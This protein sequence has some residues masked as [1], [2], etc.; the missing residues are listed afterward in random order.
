MTSRRTALVVSLSVILLAALFWLVTRSPFVPYNIRELIAQ[1]NPILSVLSLSCFLHWSFGLP[2]LL[3]GWLARGGWRAWMFPALTLLHG[4]IAWVLLRVSVP[5][6]S[7]HDVV[8]SAVLGWPWEWELIARF[9]AL[10]GVLSLAAS[11][12][13]I[14][15]MLSCTA[16]P[17]SMYL[18]GLGCALVLA[19]LLHWVVVVHASTDNLTELM[20]WGGSYPGSLALGLFL[21]IVFAAGSLLAVF[22]AR[23]RHFFLGLVCVVGSYPLA[24]L[25]VSLGTESTVIKYGQA[26]SALQFLLSA[27][28][29][30]LVDG[31]ALLIRYGL[32]HSAAVA[33][34]AS[35]Q[36]PLWSHAAGR[37]AGMRRNGPSSSK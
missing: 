25:S 13:A 1:Q 21:L 37:D 22:L 23:R 31:P 32:A 11:L 28:R 17:S 5:M 7:I 26:F 35:I 19:P 24:Y 14:P 36:S 6:E 34:I 33:A 30:H 20:A 10:F 3:V 9:L 4:G 8:G 18:Y 15:G 16:R 27:D 12:A 2:V 29:S